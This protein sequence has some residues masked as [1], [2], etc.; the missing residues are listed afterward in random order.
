MADRD[1]RTP[2]YPAPPKA[3]EPPLHRAARVGDIRDIERLVGVGVPIDHPFDMRLGEGET[4]LMMTPLMVAAGSGDGA[5]HET[6]SRL[7]ELGADPSIELDAWTA[8]G[9]ACAGIPGYR[10][11]ADGARLAALL[12]AGPAPAG[13]Y[14]AWLVAELAAH[15]LSEQLEMLLAIGLDP[16]RGPCVENK[17]DPSACTPPVFTAAIGGSVGALRVLLRMGAD[18][19]AR[20]HLTPDQTALFLTRD[21]AV[22][23]A[24]IEGGAAIDH[25]DKNGRTALY[26]HALTGQ[27]D[28]VRVLLEAGADFCGSSSDLLSAGA[29]S[30][31]LDVIKL[32]VEAGIDPLAPFPDGHTALH[33]ACG[34]SRPADPR[35]TIQ[36]LVSL[37]LDVDGGGAPCVTP[38]ASALCEGSWIHVDELVR[39]GADVNA[40]S[41][42]LIGARGEREPVL[43]AALTSIDD[44]VEKTLTLLHA[45]ASLDV[46]DLD[47]HAP[48]EV[49]RKKLERCR[50]EDTKYGT[51]FWARRIADLE[52][53]LE[54]LE[55]AD[56]H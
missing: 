33:S 50:E 48:I 32:L 49:V 10:P 13:E 21:A 27:A 26:L 16:D 56:C 53:V 38:L 44:P 54:I 35:A 43:F 5:T 12:E 4:P 17:G 45:G 46:T 31:E 30:G 9:F 34:E 2:G 55:R 8:A 52:R 19:D 29:H 24:L 28:C 11:G 15:D 14:G 37:G 6:V 39:L 3:G 18:P 41:Q 42:V 25:V 1:D 51:N 22:V 23:Q 7:I 36:Y 20:C 47:G 40:E